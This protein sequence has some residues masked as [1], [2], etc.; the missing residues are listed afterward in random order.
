MPEI[1]KVKVEKIIYHNPANNYTVAV[2]LLEEELPVTVTGSFVNIREK[3]KYI[4]TGEWTEHPKYGDQFNVQAYEPDLPKSKTDIA[5]FLGSGLLKGIGPSLA[6]RI[7]EHF[8]E[9]TLD[10]L[11]N[12]INRLRE[13]QGIGGKKF[14][15]ISALWN[16]QKVLRGLV[17]FLQKHEIN[18]GYASKLFK[19]YGS[20]A[21]EIIENNPYRLID[22]V[23]GIG[24]K[25]ADSIAMHLG[26][27]NDSPL[28]I[29]AG[30]QHLLK[31]FSDEGHNC[32]PY[33]QFISKAAE[34]FQLG[35]DIIGSCVENLIDKGILI[36][37][38]ELCRNNEDSF[39]YLD[40][41]YNAENGITKHLKSIS[42]LKNSNF[43]I[44][45]HEIKKTIE[46]L[47]IEFD[48]IQETAVKKALSEK[49]M[50]LTGGP[51]TGKTT[52]LKAI[53]NLMKNAGKKVLLAAPTGRAAKRMQ[54]ATN[55]PAVTI[56]RLLE[57]SPQEFIFARDEDNPLE[58]DYLIV[59][60]FSMVDVMLFHS[61]IKAVPLQCGML[62]VGDADQLPSVGAGNVFRDII[63][64]GSLPVIKLEKIYRQAEKSLIIQ[65]AHKINQGII[66]T[67]TNDMS[68]GDDMYFFTINSSELILETLLRLCKEEI[69]SRFG[70]DVS[71]D[72]QIIAPMYKSASGVNNLNT[73][74]QNALNPMGKVILNRN[75]EI[76]VGDKVMQ[77]RNNYE[78]D[79]YNGDVGKVT[80][81]NKREQYLI[82]MFDDKAVKY[83]YT[84]TD[85]LVLAYAVTV[86][87]AQGSEYPVIIMPLVTEH[88]PLLQRNLVYTAV[89]RGKKLV[90][91][92]GTKQALAIA[93][94]TNKSVKRFTLLSER[95][96]SVN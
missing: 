7:T 70:F 54:E 63:N 94:N 80:A 32:Y 11:D 71:R 62:L 5:A 59:D 75:F 37:E 89:T 1:I 85:E 39:I 43:F 14:D 30:L 33:R 49:I 66:P 91:L 6:K 23:W 86:H 35:H 93:V 44:Q 87:K 22:D 48:E 68:S 76:R 4:L 52:I 69:P 40:K 96:K 46:D 38:K 25:K 20:T 15:E 83:E 31:T 95:I 58:C 78:K 9:N 81:F 26:F 17:I 84:E 60:E 13:I 28:R 34:S 67:F 79:V 90:I 82:V 57:F 12:D 65:N 61:L 19:Y 10:I 55:Y 47:N 16:S 88:Y 64:S 36:L 8:G 73:V 51:G 2:C 18:A 77:T 3:D 45:M 41:F 53:L 74:L 56:H 50:I 21:Q 72:V 27:S 42:S 24:F 92:M 29:E